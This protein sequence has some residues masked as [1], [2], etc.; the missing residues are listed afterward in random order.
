M[1]VDIKQSATNFKK[2]RMVDLRKNTFYF[3]KKG[4]NADE[5]KANALIL[6]QKF[7]S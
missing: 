3:Q 1:H 2:E 5:E 7:M 6:S 4:F